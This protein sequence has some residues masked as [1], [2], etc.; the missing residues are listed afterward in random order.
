MVS[1]DILLGGIWLSQ[2]VSNICCQADHLWSWVGVEEEG[3]AGRG[4]AVASGSK[5]T[6]EGGMQRSG[7]KRTEVLGGW[8]SGSFSDSVL[9]SSLMLAL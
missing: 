9:L 2:L 6:G 4:T 8:S 5:W 3:R 7:S 1:S